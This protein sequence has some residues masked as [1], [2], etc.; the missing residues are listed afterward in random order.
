M[1]FK[2]E[3]F[4][5]KDPIEK[6]EASKSSIKDFFNDLLNEKSLLIILLWWAEFPVREKDFSKIETKNN[7]CINFFC[8]ENKL[9][10]P[11]YKPNQEFEN[12]M[13]LLLLIDENKSHYEYIKDFDRFMIH[14]MF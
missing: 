12:S 1:S 14:K 13:D 9:T 7:I 6:L 5:K 3:L 10:F 2:T 8:Y 4:E 11:I